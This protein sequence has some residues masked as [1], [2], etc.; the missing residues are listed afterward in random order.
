M[1][2]SQRWWQLRRWWIIFWRWAIERTNVRQKLGREVSVGEHLD[3]PGAAVLFQIREFFPAIAG[4]FAGGAG[5]APTMPVL[6]VVLPIGISFYTFEAISYTVDVYR[7][8][9]AGGEEPAVFPVVYHRF[10]P[11]WWPGR[12]SG[13]SNFL[14]QLRP[15]KRFSWAR[16]DLGL[17]IRADGTLQETGHSRPHGVPGGSGV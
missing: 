13:R 7:G 9:T 2:S 10:F 5:S 3:E 12:S 4:G 16:F 6:E 14:P 11:G 15:E 17:P 1:R 8:R